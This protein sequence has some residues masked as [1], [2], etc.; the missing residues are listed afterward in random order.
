MAVATRIIFLVLH[1]AL[2]NFMIADKSVE[3]WANNFS[4]N[5]ELKK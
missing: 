3:K 1:S 2:V 5:S 4:G